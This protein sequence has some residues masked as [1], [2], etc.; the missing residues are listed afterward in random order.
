MKIFVLALLLILHILLSLVALICAFF[1]MKDLIAEKNGVTVWEFVGACAEVLL[2]CLAPV[3]NIVI[4]WLFFTNKFG[5]RLDNFFKDP[6]RFWNR[7]I[8]RK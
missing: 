8:F 2:F 1:V 7:V 6:K 3:L 4:I 5:N